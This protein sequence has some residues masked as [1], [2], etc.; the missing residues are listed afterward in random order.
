MFPN[1]MKVKCVKFMLKDE[2]DC[3][4]LV[5]EIDEPE[6]KLIFEDSVKFVQI[7]ENPSSKFLKT[8]ATVFPRC[9]ILTPMYKS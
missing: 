1:L 8:K 3:S 2:I 9:N 6:K 7:V 5:K 4:T